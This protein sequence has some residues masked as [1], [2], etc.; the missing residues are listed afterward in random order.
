MPAIHRSLYAVI[1]E[2]CRRTSLWSAFIDATDALKS[3]T[4]RKHSHAS[5][6]SLRDTAQTINAV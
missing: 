2:A 1:Q 4:N 6:G 3:D 5:R